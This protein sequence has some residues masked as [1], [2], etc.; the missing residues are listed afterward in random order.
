MVDGGQQNGKREGHKDNC[1]ARS[2][3]DIS[4]R[5]NEKGLIGETI[6]MRTKRATVGVSWNTEKGTAFVLCS[7]Y[8]Q[9]R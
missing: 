5:E 4:A 6:A 9:D 8:R 7:Q 1:K 3:M 2:E